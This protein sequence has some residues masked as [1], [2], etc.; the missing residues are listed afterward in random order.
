MESDFYQENYICTC[1]AQYT[2][3]Y[4]KYPASSRKNAR[5][6]GKIK[7]SESWYNPTTKQIEKDDSIQVIKW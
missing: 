5:A 2:A 6:I 7:D 3:N 1:G 4:R